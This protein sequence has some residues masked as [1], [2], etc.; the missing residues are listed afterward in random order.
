MKAIYLGIFSWFGFKLPLEQRLE[1]IKKA[2][3]TST[4]IWLGEEEELVLNRK[5][6]LIP[7]MVRSNGL[8][9]ENVHAPY[10]ECNRIWSRAVEQRKRIRAI[11]LSCI[12][13]CREHKIPILV[14]HI[15]GGINAPKPNLYGLELMR[16]MVK[17]AE[18]SD[19]TLAVENTQRSDHFDYIFSNIT[20]THLGFC[21]DSSHD[22]MY[23]SEPGS[24]LKRWG[25]RVIA[26][27]LSDNDGVSDGH[28]LPKVGNI[29][30]SIVR[31][32][33]PKDTYCG[34]ISLEVF[35][36]EKNSLAEEFLNQAYEKA[37]WL[38]EYLGQAA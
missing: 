21:Y 23:S 35:P 13:Y 5:Q 1:L 17:F 7:N 16:D 2:G 6:D 14:I 22:F 26:T 38:A 3:F 8:F 32:H 27:H 10:K 36:K 15:S 25:S 4:S 12:M 18:E 34:T 19:V 11:Y 37:K 9:L 33:F 28:W 20:S 30:W 31:G 24:I 29:D